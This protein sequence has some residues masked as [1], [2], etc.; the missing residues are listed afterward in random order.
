MKNSG[1]SSEQSKLLEVGKSLVSLLEERDISALDI[2]DSYIEAFDE[3]EQKDLKKRAGIAKS[4]DELTKNELVEAG[5]V[6]AAQHGR[7][8]ELAAGMKDHVAQ[9]LKSLKLK[10]KGLKAYSDSYPKRISTTRPRRG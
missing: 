6:I 7:I 2:L 8:I 9:S 3:W 4:G 1:R 10:G 5:K